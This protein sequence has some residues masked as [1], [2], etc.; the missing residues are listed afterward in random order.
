[1]SYY[2][3]YYISLLFPGLWDMTQGHTFISR[4]QNFFQLYKVIG[5]SLGFKDNFLVFP[6]SAEHDGRILVGHTF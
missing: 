3:T 1:M 6:L 2:L 5:C 4:Q